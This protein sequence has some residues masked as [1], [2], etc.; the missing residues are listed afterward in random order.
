M[1]RNLRAR[2][3][4]LRRTGEV[5]TGRQLAGNLEKNENLDP[6]PDLPG[7]GRIAETPFGPCYLREHVYHP[8][9]R[10]GSMSLSGALSCTG[11]D[12]ALPAGGCDLDSFDPRQSLFIDTETTGLSG[13]TGT[14]AFLIGLGWFEGPDFQ[15]R[16]YFLRRPAE[17]RAILNHF[18]ATAEKFPTLISFNGKMF[19]LPLIQ[20]RQVLAGLKQ[21]VP[22]L[23]LDLLQCARRLWRKRLPSRSL[24]SLEETLLGLERFDD[25]PGAEIPAVYFDFL[26]RGTTGRLKK[27]FH[28]NVLDILSMVTLLER[29]SNLA[30]GRVVEHPAEAIAMGR[31]CLQAGRT[32][33]GVEYL[34]EAAESC[35]SPLAE[36]A[37]LELALH[38]KRQGKWAE[39]ESIWQNSVINSPANPAA[40]VELA[41]YYEH[42]RANYRAA[43]VLTEQALA[44]ASRRPDL[45][46][47]GELS[48]Q[49]LEH[50]LQR[51]KRRR[52]QLMP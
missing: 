46:L 7:Q 22:R 10:H 38:Y 17:E 11:K 51:L 52:G 28:H 16:Q 15:L 23:H 9:F 35:Q 5:M 37:A 8:G 34:R 44:L 27:V 12:L 31:L 29:I 2:L 47:S 14:W 39:A 1:K 3:S 24:R 13:G 6:L 20:S 40:Y 19:D 33:E 30:G 50:R 18:A 42:R 41:K 49:A 48:P 43:M 25:I 32:D 36:E 26:R 45:P 21:T 4:D